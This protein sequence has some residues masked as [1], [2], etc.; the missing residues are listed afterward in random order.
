MRIRSKA[1]AM[2]DSPQGSIASPTTHL[3]PAHV[4]AAIE[5][6]STKHETP[7]GD[8][9]I[10]WRRWGEGSPVVLMHGGSGA[11]SHWIRNIGPLSTR[12]TVWAFDIPGFGES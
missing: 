2:N 5:A 3:D 11:W 10:V 9:H 6:Q 8:G 4:V 1:F 7:C 12:H